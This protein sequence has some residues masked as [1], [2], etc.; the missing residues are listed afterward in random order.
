[1]PESVISYA[2]RTDATQEAELNALANVYKFVLSEARHAQKEAAP[3]SRPD[4]AKGSRHDRARDI[5]PERS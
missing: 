5:I 2:P 4:D 1:V 3:E